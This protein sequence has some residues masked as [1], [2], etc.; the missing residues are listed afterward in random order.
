MTGKHRW[1]GLVAALAAAMAISLVAA[2]YGAAGT[3]LGKEPQSANSTLKIRAVIDT[4]DFL[5]PQQAYTGQAWW[6]MWNVYETLVTYKHVEGAAGYQVVPG[7][8]AS[9]PKISNHGKV[10][11]FKLRKGRSE[12]HTSELQSLRHL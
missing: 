8:A 4:I 9:M 12:E 5:D 6:A 1:N 10:Y 11:K 3:Q 2:V 7:L